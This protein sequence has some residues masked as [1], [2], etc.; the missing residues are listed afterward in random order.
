MSGY[1]VEPLAGHDRS[2][3]DSGSD[4]LDRYFR[5]RITQDVRRRIA[6]GFVAIAPDG[7]VAGFYTLAPT[8][9]DFDALPVARARKLPRYP[10]VPAILL[11]RLAV[12]AQHQGVRL[13]SALVADALIR[14][15]RSEIG[16]YAMIVDAKDDAAARFYEHLGFEALP[17]SAH[18]LIRPI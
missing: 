17:S 5:E 14:C 13:G 7:A 15:R 18:R 6:T 2:A 8:S 9:L 10:L 1:V 3:F 11:G 12:A 16:G 4:T